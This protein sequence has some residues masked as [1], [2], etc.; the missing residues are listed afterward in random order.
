MLAG[1]AARYR[2]QWERWVRRFLA[3]LEPALLLV[4]GL[5][6]LLVALAVLMPVL[7]MNSQL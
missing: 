4:V 6:V 3:L 1:A 7:S 5:F 2:Q